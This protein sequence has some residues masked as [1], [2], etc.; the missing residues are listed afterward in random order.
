[1]MM[2]RRCITLLVLL[3]SAICFA[4]KATPAP[5]TGYRIAGT[6]V[7]RV[8]GLPLDDATLMLSPIA[9]RQNAISFR[10]GPD[11]HFSFLGLPPGK[12]SLGAKRHGYRMQGFEEHEFFATAIV[13]GPGIDSEHL[14]FRLRPDASVRGTITDEQNEPAPNVIVR[15]YGI[16]MENG[17]SSVRRMNQAATDDRGQFSFSHLHEGTYYIAASG[18]PWY[19]D[20]MGF[21]QQS[22]QQNIDPETKARLEQ[23]SAKLDLVYPLTFYSGALSSDD[24]T[25]IHLNAGDN[26]TADLTLQPVRSIHIRVPWSADFIASQT[27]PDQTFGR[28]GGSV[29]IRRHSAMPRIVLSQELFNGKI[30]EEL[31]STIVIGGGPGAGFN[32]MEGIAP[33]RYIVKT[34]PQGADG[35]ATSQELD[36]S[37]DMVVPSSG[38]TPLASVSG[39]IWLDGIPMDQAFVGLQADEGARSF[40]GQVKKGEFHFDEPVP[41]GRY[42]ITIGSLTSNNNFY[43]SAFTA[44]GAK[45][46][47]RTIQIT[48]GA[49]VRLSILASQGVAQVEGVAKSG[50][51]PRAGVMVLL[52]PEDLANSSGLSR[53]D[54]SDS[55]GTFTL[56]QVVPGKYKLLAIENGWNVAW[57]D[58]KVLKPLLANARDYVIQPNQK[59]QVTVEVQRAK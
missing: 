45:I 11:G 46:S 54:Q 7:D 57:A 8:T 20:Y 38:G 42:Q 16:R 31:T 6:V 50:D 27:Q 58:P 25:P 2:L 22:R 9:E 39:N 49:P 35:P 1:M 12:Y 10:T 37:G 19:S 36:L 51:K 33:G 34:N 3:V 14:L 53:R 48:S 13:V 44:T 18:R 41:P 32:E 59:L 26:V 4:Q 40:G 15:L 24:A 30:E 17:E 52:V 21:F 56:R 5:A 47:G 55:D 43:V 29:G 28:T 23:E